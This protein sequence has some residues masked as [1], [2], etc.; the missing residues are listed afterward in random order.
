MKKLAF[1]GR[2]NK[3]SARTI[4]IISYV[5]LN[6]IALF[7]GDVIHSLNIA[8][9]PLFFVFATVLTL[10]GWM[11]YPSKS[12]KKEYRNFFMRQKSADLLLVSATFLFIVYAG[13]SLNRN[14][15]TFSNPVQAISIIHPT[16]PTNITHAS[17]AKTTVTKKSL[18]KKIRAEIKSIRKAYKDST[19]GQKTLYIIL[20]ILAAAG[21]AYG[22]AALACG[23][24][25]SGSEALAIVV[26]AV[27]LGG[28]IFG[29]IKL[30]QRITRGGPKS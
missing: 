5:F 16:S 18:R 3:N 13:N 2:A 1:W 23:I 27:G 6:L 9:T 30:I 20:A 19:K 14:W 17:S 15:N 8:F 24:S 4:I 21:L 25:C 26:F 22:L 7:L 11:I 29:V 12:R 28:I 10:V